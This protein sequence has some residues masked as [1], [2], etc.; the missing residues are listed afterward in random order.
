MSSAIGVSDS[1][2]G[3]NMAEESNIRQ[4]VAP[5]VPPPKS[6]RSTILGHF[7]TYEI[8]P[9]T[10]G[11]KNA[12]AAAKPSASDVLINKATKK[13]GTQN[14]AM[15]KTGAEDSRKEKT[16]VSEI[17]KKGKEKTDITKETKSTGVNLNSRKHIN[18]AAPDESTPVKKTAPSNPAKKKVIKDARA[19]SM[20]DKKYNTEYYE[21]YDHE[22]P[23]KVD[24]VVGPFSSPEHYNK[25]PLYIKAALDNVNAVPTMGVHLDDL[26]ISRVITEFNAGQLNSYW[27]AEFDQ[28]GMIRARRIPLG[29]AAKM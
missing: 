27:R 3:M 13:T 4:E 12:S 22:N 15:K 9:S 24:V 25:Y 5:F 17:V 23:K 2:D 7:A 1:V 16:S 14:T 21:H 28:K 29:H 6:G 19:P 10:S 26:T 8:L 20:G 11:V 18:E